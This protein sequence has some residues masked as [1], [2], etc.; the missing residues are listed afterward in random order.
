M[1]MKTG[2]LLA[3]LCLCLTLSACGGQQG[4]GGVSVYDL[5]KNMLEADESLPEMLTVNSSAE[6]GAELFHYLSDLDY[7]K[8]SGYFLAYSAD[9]MADEIAVIVTK[10][11]KDT[12]DAVASLKRHV[13]GRVELYRNYEPEQVRRAEGAVVFSQDNCAVLIISDKPEAARGAFEETLAAGR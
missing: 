12:S 7:G 1:K 9:G 5:Q 10:D 4:T 2:T 11:S 6:D 8:V 13:E 3:L